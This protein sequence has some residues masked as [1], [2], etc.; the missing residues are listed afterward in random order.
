MLNE[1]AMTERRFRF[2]QTSTYLQSRRKY[3]LE[4]ILC[5]EKDYPKNVDRPGFKSDTGTIGHTGMHAYY[6]GLPLEECLTAMR[7]K[8]QATGVLDTPERYEA[9][10]AFQRFVAWNKDSNLDNGL[11]PVMIEERIEVSLG[12]ILGDEVI[13]TG[14]PDIVLK[15]RYGL[16]HLRDW[17][18]VE[19][20]GN[21][22]SFIDSN[23]QLLT[24][25]WLVGQKLGT[26]PTT[27]SLNQIRRD[28]PKT[29]PYLPV[30][31]N[32]DYPKPETIEENMR[33]MKIALTEMVKL[34]QE[35]E[36]GDLSGVIAN[37]TM[38]CD[39]MCRKYEICC[40]AISRTQKEIDQDIA[41]NYRKKPDA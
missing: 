31:I 4:Y 34:H 24:Y 28:P 36:N 6:S 32:T 9:E 26:F 5:L 38:N 23:R 37:P 33:Q 30:M 40:G 14:E 15:D 41:T 18:F 12:D 1:I 2:S 17:K 20:M 8:A 7:Q 25:C 10:T 3:F 22:A 29:V 35:V 13:L 16:L 11:T 27:M 19:R 39:R 21:L